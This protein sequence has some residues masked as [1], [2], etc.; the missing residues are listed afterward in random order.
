MQTVEGMGSVFFWVAVAAS[1]VFLGVRLFIRLRRRKQKPIEIIGGVIVW[2][3]FVLPSVTIGAY[4]GSLIDNSL[5]I[6]YGLNC[7][8]SLVGLMVG[9][10]LW[11]RANNL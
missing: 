10:Y 3:L 9:F 7:A 8:F 5:D 1:L 2:G 11:W 6:T 4:L